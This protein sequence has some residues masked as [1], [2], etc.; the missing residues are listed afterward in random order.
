MTAH[1]SVGDDA[2]TEKSNADRGSRGGTSRHASVEPYLTGCAW[3]PGQGA[4]YPRADPTDFSR[5]PIDTWG[6]ATVP[7][8]VRLEFA[9]AARAVQIAYRTRTSD[10]GYRGEGAGTEFTAYQREAR[11][12]SE[13][14]A[15]GDG[16][17]TP[18]PAGPD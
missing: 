10:L 15:L 9:G 12:T 1:S 18:D 8:G 17:V 3:P 2:H 7:V 13:P 11:I 4:V 14:A 5:L 6:T 16:P